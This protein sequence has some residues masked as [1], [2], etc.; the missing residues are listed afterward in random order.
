MGIIN[1]LKNKKNASEPN[2]EDIERY[3]ATFDS[4][5]DAV[6]TLEPPDW[7]FT[8]G[9]FATLRMFNCLTDGQF[10]SLPPW[11]LSPEKQPDGQLSSD[12][13]KEMIEKAMQEGSNFFEWTHKK[14]NGPEF[15]ATVLLTKIKFGDREFLQA[16]VR[17]ISKEKAVETQLRQKAQETDSLKDQIKE[18]E[19]KLAKMEK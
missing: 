2:I 17:D 19:E 16:I 8:K 10:E 9:N 7:K 15:P 1:F 11:E 6:M 3:K 4:M 12:K 5:N 18:L 14:Y 13:A